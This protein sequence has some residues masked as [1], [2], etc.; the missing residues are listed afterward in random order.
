MK[1]HLTDGRVLEGTPAEIAEAS[2]LLANGSKPHSDHREIAVRQ[3]RVER[4]RKD[5]QKQIEKLDK[6]LKMLKLIQNGPVRSTR[7]VEAMNFEKQL[8]LAWTAN[9]L[10]ALLH[11]L[12]FDLDHVY[13]KDGD[14]YSPREE[15]ANAIR[16]VET[17]KKEGN[18]S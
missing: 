6:A 8:E 4:K 7:I 5:W 16:A 9:T 1:L 11:R 2:R 12:S 10:N 18:P 13:V 15:I 17:K 3:P 14:T